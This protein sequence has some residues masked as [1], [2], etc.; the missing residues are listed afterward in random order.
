MIELNKKGYIIKVMIIQCKRCG[1]IKGKTHEC[2]T[3]IS[4]ATKQKLTEGLK[5]RWAD[6]AFKEKMS[7]KFKEIG[8]TPPS[9]K[10]KKRGKQTPEHKAQTMKNLINKSG[11]EHFAWMGNNVGYVALHDWVKVRLA[12]PLGCNQCGEIRTLQLSN[13]SQEYKRELSDW[14]YLCVPC[15]KK[16]DFNFKGKKA[17]QKKQG[18][19]ER[20]VI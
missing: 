17:F 3:G 1:R 20:S 4:I 16:Y 10:G 7:K 18:K 11:V 5:K 13:I 6:P 14:I 9:W 19:M 15:H 2:P 12:K 8:L